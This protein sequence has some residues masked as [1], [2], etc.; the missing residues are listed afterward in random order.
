[1]QL[2]TIKD[3]KERYKG[4]NIGWS[5]YEEPENLLPSTIALSLG[6]SM[7]E[8]HGNKYFKI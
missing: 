6:A 8:K 3:L 2:N 1:M 5:I 7:F 4:I